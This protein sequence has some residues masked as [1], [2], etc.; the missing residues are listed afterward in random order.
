LGLKEEDACTCVARGWKKN[1]ELLPVEPSVVRAQNALKGSLNLLKHD[2]QK[3]KISKVSALECIYLPYKS[4][5]KTDFFFPRKLVYYV[6]RGA[7]L[8]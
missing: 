7:G 2:S 1:G 5:T 6:K 8:F 3:K 4:T